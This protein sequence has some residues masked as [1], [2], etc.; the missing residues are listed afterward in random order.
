MLMTKVT[1]LLLFVLLTA[2]NRPDNKTLFNEIEQQL[3]NKDYFKASTTFSLHKKDLSSFHQLKIETALDNAFNRLELSNQKIDRLFKE[4]AQQLSDSAKRDLLVLKQANDVKLF[5]Y[6]DAAKTNR[7][8]LEK[9]DSLLT[10]EERKD[11][12][13]TNRIWQALA[14]QPKQTVAVND[15]AILDIRHDKA[16]LPNLSV[17]ADTVQI[18]FIFDTGANLSTVTESTAKKLGMKFTEGT[19]E[20]GAITGIAVNARIAVCPEFRL[21]DVHIRN[22]VFLV[23]PDSAMAFPQINYQIHGILGFPVIEALKEI[24][25]TKAGQFIIPKK[26]SVISTPNLALDFLTPIIYI[27]GENFTFDSGA[28][29]TILY[30][31][32]YEKHKDSIQQKYTE[33]VINIGGAGGVLS[34]KGYIIPL[35]LNI[36]GKAVAIDSV[37]LLKENMEEGKTHLSGNIGQDLIKKFSKMTINFETMFVKFD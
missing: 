10:E 15:D 32:Y 21:K 36:A 5:A 34:K 7:E 14:T 24:Q 33:T 4:Y 26:R 12:L 8:I 25:L 22:A 9:Y 13:N 28:Q 17:S 23:F 6:D 20:I 37:R 18:D 35:H 31:S 1:G 16:G 3:K 11:Y 27:N 30:Q 19:A 2:C 29:Q